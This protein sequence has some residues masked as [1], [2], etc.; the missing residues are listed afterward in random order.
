MKKLFVLGAAAALVCPL[1]AAE[2]E[3]AK[4]NA[5]SAET[6]QVQPQPEEKDFSS[7]WP[8]WFALAQVPRSPDVVGMRITIPF[9]TAQDNVTGIDVGFWG[10]CLYFEGFQLNLLRNDAKDSC[11][12]LQVGLYNSIGRGDLAGMQVGLWNEA[13]SLTGIQA[14]VINLVGEGRGFQVGLINRAETFSGYQVG[15]VNVIR[16]AELRFMPLINIGF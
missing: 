16:D 8:V 1:F 3:S 13:M 4:E 5:A 12:G 7:A 6:V 2:S 9:S 14:G 11:T 15:L 10:R